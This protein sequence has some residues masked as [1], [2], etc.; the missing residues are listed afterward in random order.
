MQLT[1][2]PLS[3]SAFSLAALLFSASVFAA[4]ISQN[5]TSLGPRDEKE[6]CYYGDELT[7]QDYFYY[8]ELNYPT[9]KIMLWSGGSE[10]QV[11]A[12]KAVNPDYL[13]YEDVFTYEPGNPYAR[14]WPQDENKCYRPDNAEASSEAIAAVAT[15][16]VLAFGA[17]QWSQTEKGRWTF[18]GKQEMHWVKI[19][20]GNGRLS[21]MLHMV[22]DTTDPSQVLAE[23]DADGKITY[24][25]GYAD[26]T[27]NSTGNFDDGP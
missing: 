7:F 18:F 5:L 27:P 13:Y 26:G 1:M 10:T 4:P 24:V 2:S 9:D 15:G 14:T 8:L 22:K 19:N 20:L 3:V 6:P 11:Q 12:F 17:V 21:K 25:N 23:E 16:D